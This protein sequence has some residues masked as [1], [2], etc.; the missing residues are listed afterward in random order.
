MAIQ[1]DKLNEHQ[2]VMW[3]H[4]ELICREYTRLTGKRCG[5][6]AFMAARFKVN[7]IEEL[8]IAYLHVGNDM[9]QQCIDGGHPHVTFEYAIL[10]LFPQ[11]FPYA[12]RL[13]A[14]T[15]IERVNKQ[16][17]PTE[18]EREPERS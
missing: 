18:P 6:P 1:K 9:L 5:S 13:L 11:D 14:S 16:P 2:L 3:N 10:Y 12:D 17:E 15:R 4:A 8:Y 7:T